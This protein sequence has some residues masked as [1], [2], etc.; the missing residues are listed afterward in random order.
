MKPPARGGSQRSQPPPWTPPA[1]NILQAATN[2]ELGS[3]VAIHLN[4]EDNQAP[5]PTI[6]LAK[7]VLLDLSTKIAMFDGRADMYHSLRTSLLG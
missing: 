7:V 4:I 5:H 6:L 2:F 1:A 3:N